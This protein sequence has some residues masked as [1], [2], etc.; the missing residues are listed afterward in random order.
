MAEVETW[1]VKTH[2]WKSKWC[3]ERKAAI[4]LDYESF[5]IY[6]SV[7][8]VGLHATP[9]SHQSFMSEEYSFGVI[10]VWSGTRDGSAG[11]EIRFP[12]SLPRFLGAHN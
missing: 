12:D 10:S 9:I 2:Y 11:F 5:C 3:Q 6:F 8:P 7:Q 1:I 4:A